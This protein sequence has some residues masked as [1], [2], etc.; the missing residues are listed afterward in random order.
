MDRLIEAEYEK[1]LKK[2]EDLSMIRS[3]IVGFRF[4]LSQFL[5]FVSFIIMFQFGAMIIRDN[6]G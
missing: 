1:K 6:E 2:C 3:N 4:G 5:I